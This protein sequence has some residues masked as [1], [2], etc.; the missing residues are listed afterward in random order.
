[1]VL[2]FKGKTNSDGIYI[3]WIAFRL[4]N[5]EIVLISRTITEYVI[6]ND[7]SFDMKWKGCHEV[8]GQKHNYR[9]SPVLLKDAKIADVMLTDN[10]PDRYSISI[11]E[12][13]AES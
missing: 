3:R 11:D 8:V 2:K 5:E 13:R 6:E 4:P 7:G 1:M 10:A 12:F 9:I